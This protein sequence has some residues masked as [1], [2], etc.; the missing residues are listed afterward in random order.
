MKRNLF[1]LLLIF[2]AVINI[3]AFGRPKKI[4]CNKPI[5]FFENVQKND[6]FEYLDQI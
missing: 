3:A 1:A 6:Y 5:Y 4:E 2:L